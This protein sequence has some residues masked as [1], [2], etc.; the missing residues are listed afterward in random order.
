MKLSWLYFNNYFITDNEKEMV[1]VPKRM[2]SSSNKIFSDSE[3]LY[4]EQE[5]RCGFEG[6]T[7]ENRAHGIKVVIPQGA[8]PKDETFHFDMAVTSSEF[9]FGD[10]NRRPISPYLWILPHQDSISSFSKPISITLPHIL[11]N[12]WS[13]QDISRFGLS[14]SKA[15]HAQQSCCHFKECDGEQTFKSGYGELQTTHCCCLCISAI[16]SPEV[17]RDLVQKAGYCLTTVECPCGPKGTIYF[18]VSFYLQHFI[19]VI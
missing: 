16:P 13:D 6:C 1:S 2:H 8:I 7:F 17:A 5:F 9:K 4:H 18:C 10:S 11:T 15:V 3:F 14:F 19:S 12:E